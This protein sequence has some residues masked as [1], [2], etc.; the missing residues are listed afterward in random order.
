MTGRQPFLFCGDTSYYLWEE[1]HHWVGDGQTL[2]WA[3][4]IGQ[5]IKAFLC[6]YILGLYGIAGYAQKQIKNFKW[7]GRKASLL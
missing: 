5:P 2:Q 7:I 1:I 4:G 3:L 6:L